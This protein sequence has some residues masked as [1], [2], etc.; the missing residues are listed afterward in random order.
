MK[1][2][3]GRNPFHVEQRPLG[4][5]CRQY[6]VTPEQR[7]ACLACRR[8]QYRAQQSVETSDAKKALLQRQRTV[9]QHRPAQKTLGS[10]ATG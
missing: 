7:E 1:M 5:S 9:T 10:P 3:S 6:N 4:R 8:L 2:S